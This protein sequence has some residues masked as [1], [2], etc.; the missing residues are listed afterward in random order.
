M[1]CMKV[2]KIIKDLVER[3]ERNKSEYTGRGYNEFQL[4]NE[5]ITPFFEALGWDVYNKSGAAPAY[6]DV[7]LEDS[8]KIGGGT[9]ARGLW[10]KP[11]DIKRTLTAP[12]PFLRCT[13]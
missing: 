7:I 9:K 5:F 1:V 6:R 2:P 12:L 3:Y 13:I 10:C 4:R 11:F 8:I